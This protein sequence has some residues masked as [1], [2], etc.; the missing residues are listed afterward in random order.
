M[1]ED[2][3]PIENCVFSFFFNVILV[4]GGVINLP[5]FRCFLPEKNQWKELLLHYL[6]EELQLQSIL[7]IDNIYIY[8]LYINVYIAVSVWNAETL[9]LW[10]TST[11][12]IYY[13]S[14]SKFTHLQ[15]ISFF[16][17]CSI[18]TN[19]TLMCVIRVFVDSTIFKSFF[20]LALFF[21]VVFLLRYSPE[22]KQFRSTGFFMK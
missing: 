15:H 5:I 4:F 22:L 16:F 9:Q 13:V 18:F 14:T 19:F 8:I 2:V 11:S 3:F 21:S 20:W 7:H 10:K 12:T 1:N 6:C 17:K